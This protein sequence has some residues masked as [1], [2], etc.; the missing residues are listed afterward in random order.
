MIT[1]DHDPLNEVG[2]PIRLV[3]LAPGSWTVMLGAGAMV[4]GPLFGFLVG[5]MVGV[6][7]KTLGM[8]PIFFFLLV[9]FLVAGLGLGLVL[10]GATR[11]FA[12]LHASSE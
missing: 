5:T 3:P 7:R 4:L 10:L 9:G 8:S 12:R 1:T 11:I 2:S 6:D